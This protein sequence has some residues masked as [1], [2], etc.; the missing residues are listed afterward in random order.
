MKFI[1]DNKALFEFEFDSVTYKIFLISKKYSTTQGSK[2]KK[3]WDPNLT[4]NN[5]I[6]ICND[7]LRSFPATPYDWF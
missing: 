3:Y 2:Q 1:L 5:K 6:C 4:N 7:I